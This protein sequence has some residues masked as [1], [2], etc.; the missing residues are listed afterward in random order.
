MRAT[1]KELLY[2]GVV[3]VNFASVFIIVSLVAV[4]FWR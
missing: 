4:I 3:M 2:W 1:A